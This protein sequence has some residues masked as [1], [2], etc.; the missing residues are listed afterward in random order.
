M[1]GLAQHA[2]AECGLGSLTLLVSGKSGDDGQSAAPFFAAAAR[3]LRRRGGPSGGTASG[4]AWA[5]V[6][7]SF[8]GRTATRL[9]SQRIGAE[10]FFGDLVGFASGLLIVLAPFFFLTLTCFRCGALD[11]LVFL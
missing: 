5:L 6:V 3:R 1:A 2:A 7:V 8:Q 4:R 10:A 11:A 9:C